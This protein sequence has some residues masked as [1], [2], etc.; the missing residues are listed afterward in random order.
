MPRTSAVFVC[1]CERP[2]AEQREFNG[3]QTIA[4]TK[5][6]CRKMSAFSLHKLEVVIFF[7]LFACQRALMSRRAESDPVAS[8]LQEDTTN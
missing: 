4:P 1:V 6:A 7:V 2:R 5:V 8:Y 3:Q